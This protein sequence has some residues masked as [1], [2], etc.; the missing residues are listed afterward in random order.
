MDINHVS[1]R[2]GMIPPSKPKFRA[3]LD[4]TALLQKVSWSSVTAQPWKNTG[5]KGRASKA[6]LSHSGTF[7][8]SGKFAINDTWNEGLLVVHGFFLLVPGD[9]IRDL[10]GM[11][12]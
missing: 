6:L 3:C 12:K 1:V 11:V 10:F 5:E 4:R 9:S 2:P 7:G 8:N